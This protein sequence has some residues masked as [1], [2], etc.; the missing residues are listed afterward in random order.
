ML[1]F[2]PEYIVKTGSII[3]FKAKIDI[4]EDMKLPK[5]NWKQLTPISERKFKELKETIYDYLA[6]E[7]EVKMSQ[8][9]MDTISHNLAFQILTMK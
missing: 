9:E 7:L 1:C 4:I 5:Y 8:K 6:M 2:L 3:D